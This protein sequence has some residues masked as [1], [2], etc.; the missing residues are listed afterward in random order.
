MFKKSLLILA[1]VVS[2][3]LCNS[4]YT[5]IFAESIDSEFNFEVTPYYTTILICSNYLELISDGKL[6][7]NGDT[8]VQKGYIA[9]IKM[10]LQKL[11]DSWT[12][13]KTWEVKGSNDKVSLYKEW[14]VEKGTYRLKLTHTALDSS[15]KAVET[16]I[17]YSNVVIY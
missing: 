12:T 5:N 11:S 7:C 17:K 4:N 10:E 16:V 2:L 1:T 9:G 3:V 8:S 6:G 15:G 13:I 14:Y